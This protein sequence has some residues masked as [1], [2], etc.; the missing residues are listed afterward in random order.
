[1]RKFIFLLTIAVLTI[2]IL[3]TNRDDAPP[4]QAI[5]IPT[6]TARKV[7]KKSAA[8][9]DPSDQHACAQEACRHPA[10][11]H[12]FRQMFLKKPRRTLEADP[13]W[14]I[15]PNEGKG[16]NAI[17]AVEDGLADWTGQTEAAFRARAIQPSELLTSGSPLGKGVRFKLPLFDDYVFDAVVQ[18]SFVNVNGTVSTMAHTDDARWARAA[19]AYTDGELRVK[20]MDP[21]NHRMF[22]VHYNHEDGDH[23]ALELDPHLVATTNDCQLTHDSEFHHPPEVAA[24]GGSGGSRSVETPSRAVDETVAAGVADVMVVYP[25]NVVTEAGSEANV[26]N[27]AAQAIS[28]SNDVHETSDTGLHLQLVHTH[29]NFGCAS[30]KLLPQIGQFDPARTAFHQGRT[31]QCFKLF[32]LQRQRWLRNITGLCRAP[33]VAMGR[34]R[35]KIPHMFEGYTYHK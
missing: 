32:D 22:A 33:E 18:E 20:V 34:K 6:E 8:K 7:A 3:I 24:S 28:L 13:T 14:R 31:N 23:Y 15:I 2:A 10:A 4:E 27:L 35:L 21:E 16:H 17:A 30:Q 19:I 26:L 1:M 5:Q 11:L 12:R 25:D 29:D 9:S